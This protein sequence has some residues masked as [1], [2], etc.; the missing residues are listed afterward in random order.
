MKFFQI[1]KVAVKIAFIILNN[2]DGIIREL[3]EDQILIKSIIEEIKKLKAKP[4][5]E[6]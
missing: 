3:K 5:V 4:K 6:K 2:L 1:V